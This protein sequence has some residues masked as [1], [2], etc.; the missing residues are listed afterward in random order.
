M[1]RPRVLFVFDRTKALVV[2]EIVWKVRSMVGKEGNRMESCLY[3]KKVRCD[4]ET[5]CAAAAPI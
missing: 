1:V 5:I 3:V 4:L 2:L